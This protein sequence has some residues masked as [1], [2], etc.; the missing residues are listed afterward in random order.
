MDGGGELRGGLVRVGGILPDDR[1]G[2]VDPL[3]IPS[4]ILLEP[5][6]EVKIFGVLLNEEEPLLEIL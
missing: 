4:I 3:G 5:E 6:D 2:V 1:P